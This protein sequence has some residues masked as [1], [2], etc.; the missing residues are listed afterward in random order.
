MKT[1][2]SLLMIFVALTMN[3]HA[4]SFD[5]AKANTYVEKQICHNGSLSK[6]DEA[7]ADNYKYML[8]SDIGEG[9]AKQLKQTQKK[10][11]AQR[12]SCT[13][14]DCIENA[15]LTRIDEI[16]EYPVISGIHPE[17]LSAAD[18]N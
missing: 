13:T 7:M 3:A 15:Y 11:L 2:L 12:N 5:C 1:Q 8:A 18:I 10:W 14:K 6:L 9:A 16:C 4:A 17:C